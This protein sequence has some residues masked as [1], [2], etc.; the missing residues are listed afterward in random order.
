LIDKERSQSKTGGIIIPKDNILSNIVFLIYINME[1]ALQNKEILLNKFNINEE[2]FEDEL[3]EFI[4]YWTE[5]SINWKKE[6]WEKEK[7]FDPNRRFQRWL[8]NNK[9]WN[10]STSKWI[11]SVF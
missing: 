9:K 3:E 5:K 10:K 4:S 11:S 1:L 7:T 8:R 6:R 2:E